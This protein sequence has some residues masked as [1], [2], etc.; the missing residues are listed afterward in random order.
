VRNN[1][2]YSTIINPPLIC[3]VISTLAFMILLLLFVSAIFVREAFGMPAMFISLAGTIYFYFYA[4]KKTAKDPYWLN[5][6]IAAA[7]F[8]KRRP[9]QFLIRIFSKKDKVLYR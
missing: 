9:V 3:G 4:V 5:T 2:I 7:L 6:V 8:E 1:I